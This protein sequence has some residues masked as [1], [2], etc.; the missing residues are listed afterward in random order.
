MQN[1]SFYSVGLGTEYFPVPFQG[2]V[3]DVDSE[4]R[5][6]FHEL[7]TNLDRPEVR[8]IVSE[9]HPRP[10]AVAGATAPGTQLA[11]G[12]SEQSLAAV[13]VAGCRPGRSLRC[14]PDAGGAR[15][16]PASASATIR[17]PGVVQHLALYKGHVRSDP[18]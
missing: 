5:N 18:V 16:A 3:D 4:T 12:F 9:T 7:P 6:A 2:F 14:G 13:E 17:H 8:V 1:E 10:L 15:Q 11:S